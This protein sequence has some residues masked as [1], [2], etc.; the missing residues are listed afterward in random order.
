MNTPLPRWQ[1]R[2]DARPA[3]IIQAALTL[4]SD[5]GFAATRLDDVAKLAGVT[6]GT[7]YLYFE[8]KEELFKAVV[9][10]TVVPALEFAETLVEEHQGAW[11]DLLWQLLSS[12]A[13]RMEHAT[14]SG[15]SRLMIA[16]ATNF[17]ELARF[18]VD[19][20]VVRSRRLF[21]D[22]ISRGI[23]SG[24]FREVDP[25]MAARAVTAPLVMIKVWKQ[26][27]SL[28]DTEPVDLK[29][30]ARFHFDLLVQGLRHR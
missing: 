2:K 8:N 9:R 29:A 14:S 22:V 10:E 25:M 4:F 16:E 23:Q 1:R 18:Y 11:S 3:E 15:I 13:E 28:C 12:W 17:P 19:E 5:K 27:F 24:E 7:V 26:S 30:F 20:V 6:K 21:A